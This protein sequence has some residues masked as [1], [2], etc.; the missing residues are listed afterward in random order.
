[1]PPHYSTTELYLSC[2]PS[3]CYLSGEATENVRQKPQRPW[4]VAKNVDP[5]SKKRHAMSDT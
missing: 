1:M 3:L 4:F 5:L 2:T